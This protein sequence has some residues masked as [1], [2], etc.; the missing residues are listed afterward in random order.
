[1]PHIFGND[2]SPN[3]SPNGQIAI[4]GPKTVTS[5]ILELTILKTGPNEIFNNSKTAYSSFAKFCTQL[6]RPIGHTFML[7]I[8]AQTL[9]QVVKLPLAQN[10]A[11][12]KS[13]ITQKWLTVALPNFEHNCIGQF[14][15][16]L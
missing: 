4:N 5:L 2:F 13:L 7:M 10:T 6:Y 3:F 8:L 11:Q 14:A 1:M 9:A 12:M 15:T 16:H